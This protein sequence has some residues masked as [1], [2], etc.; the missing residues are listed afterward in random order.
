MAVQFTVFEDKGYF[1]CKF[2]GTITDKECLE[3]WKKFFE[4]GQWQPTLNEFT[5]LGEADFSKL[6]VGGLRTLVDHIETV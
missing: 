4:S 5:D 1:E 6:T 3:E 2:S